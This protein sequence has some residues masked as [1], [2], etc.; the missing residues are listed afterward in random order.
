MPAILDAP[1]D[2]VSFAEALRAKEY[3]SAKLRQLEYEQRTGQLIELAQAEDTVFELMRAQRDARLA[4]PVKAAPFIA[5]ELNVDIE[6]LSA[7]LAEAVYQQ[8]L[9]LSEARVDFS[10]DA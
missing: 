1:L 4:W 7:L 8:L 5:A 9:E 10:G 6:R 3:W 2:L